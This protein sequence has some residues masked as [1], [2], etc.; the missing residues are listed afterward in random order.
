MPVLL[1]HGIPAPWLKEEEAEA[2]AA[3]DLPDSKYAR[4]NDGHNP[5]HAGIRRKSE[6]EQSSGNQGRPD[7][8]RW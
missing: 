1:S 8:G 2:N 7:Y 5:M 6:P 4:A 3:V